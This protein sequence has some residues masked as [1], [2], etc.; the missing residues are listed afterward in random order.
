MLPGPLVSIYQQYKEDTNAV[1]SWL[2]STAKS[3]GYPADLLS[4]SSSQAPT[5]EASKRL[6]GK[7]R[8]QAKAAAPQSQGSAS[9]SRP[10]RPDYTI[11]IKDFIPLAEFVAASKK[12]VVSVPLAFARTLNRVIST[13][14]GF[15]GRLTDLGSAP[16][17]FAASKHSYFVGVLE[18]VRQVLKPRVPPAFQD[19]ANPRNPSNTLDEVGGRFA[20]L[21]VYEPSEEFLNAPDIERPV[22]VKD[23]NAIYVAGP[24]QDLEEALFAYTLMINDLIKIRARIEWIWANYRDGVS[25]PASAAVATNTA[26]DLARNLMEDMAP[27]F[28]AHGG[29]VEIANKFYLYQCAVNGFSLEKMAEFA[30]EFNYDT[31]DIANDTYMIPFIM[32]RSFLDI[33][34]PQHLPLY[35][36]GMYGTYDPTRDWDSMSN[37]EK[38][39]QDKVLMMEFFTELVTV[40]RCISNYPVCDEFIR[41]MQELDR[42][43]EIPMYH[44]TPTRGTPPPSGLQKVLITTKT[45]RFYL[46]PAHY[47]KYRKL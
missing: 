33:L 8:K 1:A 38:F 31:Y 36:E 39:Q 6:K 16:S 7:A 20:G 4:R 46:H 35:K 22:P 12:P 34:D 17:D 11:A 23:D 37:Q 27:I 21:S 29:P 43:Q 25:E 2:A 5:P 26:C 41:G 42:T 15:G 40:A 45:Q 32:I 30:N 18:Q 10:A 3:C 14:S 19:A 13:R 28:K 9:A 24:L 44:A 47:I